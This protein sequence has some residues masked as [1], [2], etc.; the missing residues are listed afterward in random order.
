MIQCPDCFGVVEKSEVEDN[1]CPLCDYSPLIK[2]RG[3]AEQKAELTEI[4]ESDQLKRIKKIIS[5]QVLMNVVGKR[6]DQL[7]SRKEFEAYAKLHGYKPGWVWYMWDKKRK[8][9]I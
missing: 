5:D 2:K 3:Y 7:Q 1:A 4:K 9:T 6:V 8:G